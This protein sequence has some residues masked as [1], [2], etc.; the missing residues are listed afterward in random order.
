MAKAFRCLN[1]HRSIQYDHGNAQQEGKPGKNAT[2]V[3]HGR[4]PTAQESPGQ[5]VSLKSGFRRFGLCDGASKRGRVDSPDLPSSFDPS[6]RSQQIANE[7]PETREFVG[8][9][10]VVFDYVEC[11]VVRPGEAPDGDR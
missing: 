8:R 7:R 6:P 5:R 9:V 10:G 3:F 11:E 2:E 4:H 1:G